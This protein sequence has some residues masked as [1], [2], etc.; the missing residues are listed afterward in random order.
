MTLNIISKELLDELPSS[1]DRQEDLLS[2]KGLMT[3]LKVRMMEDLLSAELAENLD[4][5][6]HSDPAS[7]Q[8]NPRNGARRKVLKGNEGAVLID[9]PTDRH[10]SFEPELIRKDQAQIDSM[11]DKII[12]L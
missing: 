9:I 12:G 4:Y 6:P 3:E 8:I 2:D 10:G 11:D 5:K 1:V 7:Q